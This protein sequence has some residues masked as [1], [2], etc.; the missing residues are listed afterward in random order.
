MSDPF[1][2][3]VRMFAGTFAPVGWLLCDGSLQAISA[4][5]SLFTLMGTTYGGDGQ[6]TFA[7]PDL[8][9]AV[10]I[11]QGPGYSL[12]NA[13]GSETVTLTA[14]Q[15]PR[16]SHSFFASTDTATGESPASSVLA[17]SAT[18]K[19]YI[20]DAPDGNLAATSLAVAGGSAPHQNLQPFGVLTYIIATEGIFPPQS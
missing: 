6:T 13:G 10:P 14:D 4:Y 18:I 8:R 11:H 19:M 17:N 7:L 2:G 20:A 15:A 1:I 9:G 16:H 12:G 5:D 3:E